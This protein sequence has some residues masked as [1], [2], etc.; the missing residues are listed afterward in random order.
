M[1]DRGREKEIEK[2]AREFP[3]GSEPL[4]DDDDD[5]GQEVNV[6]PDIFH[7]VNAMDTEE[8]QSELR[9]ANLSARGED[10]ELKV[11]LANH[12]QEELEKSG[13]SGSN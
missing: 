1:R 11:R 3:P 13:N 12:L 4:D 5:D 9:K 10:V 8:L 2:N 6:H 7:K